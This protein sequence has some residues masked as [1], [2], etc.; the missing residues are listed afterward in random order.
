MIRSELNQGD[1]P[2]ELGALEITMTPVGPFDRGVRDQYEALGVDRL[3]LLP[4]LDAPA[5]KRHDPVP[6]DDIL[7]TIDRAAETMA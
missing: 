4:G 3:V 1:R 7:R 2:A 5:G 6:V